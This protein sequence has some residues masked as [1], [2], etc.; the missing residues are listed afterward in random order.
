MNVACLLLQS[1]PVYIAV[2]GKDHKLLDTV[3]PPCKEKILPVCQSSWQWVKVWEFN[4]NFNAGSLAFSNAPLFERQWRRMFACWITA[5]HLESGNF[6][7]FLFLRLIQAVWNSEEFP[8][9]SYSDGKSVAQTRAGNVR[10]KVL[11][12]AVSSQQPHLFKP[13]YHVAL[14]AEERI[15][16][17]ITCTVLP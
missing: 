15:T 7:L 5:Q 10:N 2:Q 6:F 14:S 9:W 3:W 12:L 1:L 11:S 13:V 16:W 4:D 8:I 17:T